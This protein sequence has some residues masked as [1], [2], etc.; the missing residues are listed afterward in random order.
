[1]PR[2]RKQDPKR[3]PIYL[4]LTDKQLELLQRYVDFKDY[5]SEQDAIR[6]MIDGLEA[7]LARQLASQQDI[8]GSGGGQAA[9]SPR[10]D[11][12]RGDVYPSDVAPSSR[13][14]VARPTQDS[15]RPPP[16]PQVGDFA[17][18]PSV[19]LPSPSWND[20]SGD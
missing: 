15:G 18:R 12:P 1:M 10:R 4:R 19:G 8:A 20:E 17:G 6:K 16:K 11:A 7:W 2:R 13:G 5:D 14:D 9:T 3:N